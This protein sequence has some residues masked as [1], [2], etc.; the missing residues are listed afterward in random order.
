MQ[1]GCGCFLFIIGLSIVGA[2]IFHFFGWWGLAAIGGIVI[3]MIGI[4]ALPN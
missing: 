2:V 4:T 1:G 3:L